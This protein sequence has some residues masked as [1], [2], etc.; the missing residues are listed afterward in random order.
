MNLINYILQ[1]L[2]N[3]KTTY[4]SPNQIKSSQEVNMVKNLFIHLNK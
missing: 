4:I 3:T 1:A 2:N